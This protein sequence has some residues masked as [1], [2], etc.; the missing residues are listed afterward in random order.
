MLPMNTDSRAI[1]CCGCGEYVRA[2]LT[3]G[4]EI[5]P[6]RPDLRELP[7]WRCD[8]CGNFV[9][10]HHQTNDPTRPLGCI[11]TTE[12]RH[13]RKRIH[14]VLDPLWKSGRM[15]RKAVYASISKALGFKYHTAELRCMG[16]AARVLGVVEA[17]GREES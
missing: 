11:P 17:L 2:R 10:C 16:D 14:A 7:F 15:K 13:A 4:G 1:H 6:H 8:A 3:N 9:G 12:L 5:Y